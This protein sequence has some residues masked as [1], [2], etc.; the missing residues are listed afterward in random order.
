M[1]ARVEVTVQSIVQT[2]LTPT[3]AA[4]SADGNKWSNAG[5][6][7]L[8]VNNTGAEMTAT[9]QTPGTV[10]GL[11]VGERIVTVPLTTGVK[12]IGPLKPSVY[13]QSDGMVYVDTSRQSDVTIGVFRL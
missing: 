12:W 5:D 1:G 9:V 6:S 4:P 11:A 2:G 3:Y 7:F 13:N 8:V 10:E